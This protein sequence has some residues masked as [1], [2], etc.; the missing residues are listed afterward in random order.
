M[1][2]EFSGNNRRAD[3]FEKNISQIKHILTKEDFASKVTTKSFLQTC[4]AFNNC[5]QVE[6]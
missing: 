4:F 2:L 6:H 3:Y 5:K 1:V